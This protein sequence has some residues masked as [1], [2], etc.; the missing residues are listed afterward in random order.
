MKKRIFQIAL[1]IVIFAGCG[2][3][4]EQPWKNFNAYFNTYYNAKQ[5]YEDGLEENLR[6]VA[7]VNPEVPLEVFPPPTNAGRENFNLA[8]DTGA[9]ILRD[10]PESKYIEPSIAI[11]GKSYFYRADYFAAL[12]KFQELQRVS[13]GSTEQEA[14]FWQGRVYHQMGNQV[15]GI[16]FLQQEIDLI[17]DWDSLQLARTRLILAQLHVDQEEWEPAASLLETNIERIES[18]EIQSRAHFLYGQ[19]LERL[20]RLEEAGEAYSRVHPSTANYDLL[21]NANRKEAEILRKTGQYELAY[22]LFRSMERSDKNI[23]S[24]TELQY[25]VART[26]QLMG[27]TERA[28]EMYENILRNEVRTPEP[29]TRAKVFNGQAEIYRFDYDDFE[30]AAAY[31]DSASQERVDRERLPEDFNATELARSFGEYANVKRE[32]NH[33]DSLLH[34]GRLEP[35]VFDSVIAEIRIQR[36]QEV[37]KELERMQRQ[38]DQVI[39]VDEAETV[40]AEASETTEYGFLNIRN[41]TR[42][43]DASLQFQAIWGDRPLADNWRREASI[44]TSGISRLE[45]ED[46]EV[47]VRD[48]EVIE[49][50]TGV[51]VSLD[52]S[53][54]PTTPAAQDSVMKR[55]ENRYYSLANVFF[56]SLDMP[57]SAKVYYERIVT[58][59]QNP[60]LIPRSLYSLSEIELL[61]NNEDKAYEWANRLVDE[62]PKTTYADRIAS[63]LDIMI[64]ADSSTT[65]TFVEDIYLDLENRKESDPAE[66]AKELQQ[67]AHSGALESQR[68]LILFEAAK[69]YMRA[70]KGSEPDSVDSIHRWFT[71]HEEWE[72]H[73]EEFSSLKDSA[74]VVLADSLA[75]E[76]EMSYWQ[77]IADSTLQEPNFEAIFPFEGAYWDSTRSVLE[78][79]ENLYASSEIT[80]VASRLKE[81]LE[82]PEPAAE[83]VADSV[84]PDLP[85]AEEIGEG[86]ETTGSMACSEAY[87]G[88]TIRGGQEQ[89]EESIQYPNW[90]ARTS[91]SG[92]LTYLLKISPDGDV[93]EYDQA[94]RMDRSGIPQVFEEAIEENLQFEPHGEGE[95]IECEYTF[96]YQTR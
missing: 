27:E 77:Q 85:D 79:I 88:L 81:T 40:A 20:D 9:S 16:R 89:F 22:E 19:V 29:L 25:E 80:P 15:E 26:V 65:E 54:I 87:P 49:R 52:L 61:N 56:L 41:Q 13:T 60:D 36:Q 66:N 86:V 28:L 23:D 58:N 83:E 53:E 18:R 51:Q 6:Q 12:E 50:Q 71:T 48:D 32:I 91:L 21:F 3:P 96:Q 64:Q 92:E 17:E 75:P 30:M 55:I 34:L 67:L 57:D 38:E 39:N 35:E 45:E 69:E 33:L 90:A 63:R 62:Y 82:P 47:I 14:V 74:S 4:L 11:I 2:T 84:Q 72:K 44:S 68:P 46:G 7:D 93:L 31:Y 10:H 43:A 37:E 1:I 94:S 95:V 42:L 5:Y 78:T 8:I 73:R 59:D 24:R 76:S 70:A